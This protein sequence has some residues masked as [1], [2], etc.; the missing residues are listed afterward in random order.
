MYK[1]LFRNRKLF[2]LINILKI[3]SKKLYHDVV[4]KLKISGVYF[5]NKDK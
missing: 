3:G 4:F 1:L 2:Q 5:L